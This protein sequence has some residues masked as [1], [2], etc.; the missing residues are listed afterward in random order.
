MATKQQIEANRKNALKST[1]PNTLEG[2]EIASK[3][4][5]KHGLHVSDAV[6]GT[7]NPDEF[8]KHREL[9]VKELAPVGPMESILAQ[10]IITL[11]WRLK[12]TESI[13]TKTIDA[14]NPL[15][16]PRANSWDKAEIKA[17][18]DP[19]RPDLDL[20]LGRIAK[21]DFAYNRVL[22]RLQ[23]YEQRIERSFHKAI[24]EFQRL[25]NIRKMKKRTQF[26]FLR[27]TIMH[28]KQR[29]YNNLIKLG[30]NKTNPNEPNFNR[31]NP[32]ICDEYLTRT[33]I[34]ITLLAVY[35]NKPEIRIN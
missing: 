23:M 17:V 27:I 32:Q 26:S 33:P 29:A 8:N 34:T 25:Q 7:E 10:R 19:N 35:G 9:I 1:G 16:N 15:Y 24:I 28:C 2:K 20:T 4:S 3:N 14:L 22:E 6:I 13:Q 31:P 30:A 12:R 11:S 18:D 21:K 5:F